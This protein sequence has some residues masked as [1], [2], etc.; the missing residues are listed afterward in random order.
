[1]RDQYTDNDPFSIAPDS[2]IEFP[3]TIGA[4]LDVLAS[5]TVTGNAAKELALG[6]LLRH[7]IVDPNLLEDSGLDSHG[8]RTW[9]GH[10]LGTFFKLLDRNLVAGFGARTLLNVPWPGGTAPPSCTATTAVTASAATSDAESSTGPST[11]SKSSTSSVSSRKLDTFS[12]ALG[13]SIEPPFKAITEG[14]S[15][16]NRWYASRKLDGV[17]VLT[18]LDFLVPTSA[19][20]PLT[21]DGITCVSRTGKEFYSLDALTDQ[22]AHLAKFPKQRE[23]LD[24]DPV[25]FEERDEGVVKRLVLDGEVCVMR[26]MTDL[27]NE[28]RRTR[29]SSSGTVGASALWEKNDHLV[30]D[31]PSTVSAIRKAGSIPHPRYF[32]FDILSWAEVD[33]KDSAAQ[34]GLG[35]TFG[36]RIPELK[37]LAEFLNEEL[38]KQSV[39]E[40]MVRALVQWEVG[41]VEEVEGM[42][43]RAA[44][45]GWEGL[46]LRADK[47]YKGSRT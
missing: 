4:L 12:C 25:T 37:E 43:Q 3:S 8:A 7:N 40:Q 10:P 36:Q 38:A 26:P 11:R 41:G 42:V 1:M 17:R 9:E 20:A 15:A 47:P 30:E 6:F 27:E 13:K 23:W 21:V 46:I 33:A 18:F 22:L 24:R 16:S 35:K 19:A 44:D 32:L 5:R 14:K 45:E 31:F 29:L 34:P 2:E 28:E 39:E